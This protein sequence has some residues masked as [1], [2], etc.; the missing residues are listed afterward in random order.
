MKFENTKKFFK[1]DMIIIGLILL[2]AIIFF[3]IVNNKSAGWEIKGK[4][5]QLNNE[6][7]DVLQNILVYDG[8]RL[9]LNNSSIV[10][11]PEFDAGLGI[12]VEGNSLLQ[13]T[14][15]Q[16]ENSDYQ[17]FINAREVDGKSPLINVSNSKILGQYAIYLR[18]RTKFEAIN[19]EIGV[20]EIRDNAN[21]SLDNSTVFPILFSEKK[22]SF[23][24]LTIGTG[25]T[26][27][28]TSQMGWT[29][30]MRNSTVTGYQIDLAKDSDY[31]IS[32][33]NGVSLS[34]TTPGDL[35]QPY[36][37]NFA[38]G[39]SASDGSLTDLG[40]NLVWRN[41]SFPLLSLH[42]QGNDDL[43]VDSS[44]V[45]EAISVENSTIAL[46]NMT[47]FCN[48]CM[49]T[50]SSKLNFNNVTIA[51]SGVYKPVLLI[52]DSAS[53]K[54]SGSDI[55]NLNI[56]VM[57]NASLEIEGSQY[58]ESKIQNLGNGTVTYN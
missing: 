21:V 32:N 9:E 33:S 26:K 19:S 27:N 8:G 34:I 13:L 20:M 31:E 38:T 35:A 11:R 12:Y 39:D 25:I 6:T 28:I 49:A 40:F 41:T 55:R 51:D 42:S 46:N 4:T 50:D 37:L 56:V 2:A 5:V 30:D 22:E 18:D 14:D 24:G 15:S 57:G 7:K 48:K 36:S 17:Y 43:S 23:D 16:I 45:N 44:K 52:V 3:L 47:V 29:L 53:V 58:D 1:T 54:F 10:M